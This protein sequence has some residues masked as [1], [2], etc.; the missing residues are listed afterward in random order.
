MRS[1]R[2]VFW[3]PGRGIYGER[4][5]ECPVRI[6]RHLAGESGSFSGS[7]HS[8]RNA[9]FT[10]AWVDPSPQHALNVIK[11]EFLKTRLNGNT[12]TS[13]EGLNRNVGWISQL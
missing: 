4:S 11:L 12:E 2:G 3:G 1:K 13:S 7:G 8:W 9:G 10:F 6:V 5:Q